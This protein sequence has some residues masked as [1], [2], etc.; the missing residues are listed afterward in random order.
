MRSRVIAKPTGVLRKRRIR[1][2]MSLAEALRHPRWRG[3]KF[4]WR[5]RLCGRPERNRPRR[6][7][8]F[9]GGGDRAGDVAERRRFIIVSE[10]VSWPTCGADADRNRPVEVYRASLALAGTPLSQG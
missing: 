6:L 3:S 7:R 5:S 2:R 9:F 10:G 8:S 1:W 4:R